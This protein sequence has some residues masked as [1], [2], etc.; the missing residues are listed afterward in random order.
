[1]KAADDDICVDANRASAYVAGNLTMREAETVERHIDQCTECRQHLS[2][3]ARSAPDRGP[4]QARSL[5]PGTRVDRYVI[6]EKIGEG[7]MGVVYHARDPELGRS[8]ALKMLRAEL[9]ERAESTL[10]ATALRDRLVREARAMAQ[11]SH[12]NVVA[13]YDLVI[14]GTAL[15]I[16]M[17]FIE[18]KSLTA[19]LTSQ[20][21]SWSDVLGVYRQAG[22]G[23]AAAHAAG[24]VHRDFKPDNVLV[25][26]GRGRT[27]VTDFGLARVGGDTRRDQLLASLHGPAFSRVTRTGAR[28][29]TPAY[30]SPEQYRGETATARSDQFSFCIALYEAL[31]HTSPFEGDTVESRAAAV[32]AGRRRA[33][34]KDE[35][36]A[37]IDRVV[38]R[39]MRLAPG[40]RYES[41]AALLKALAPRSAKPLVRAAIALA[42]LAAGAGTTML[43]RRGHPTRTTT[44]AACPSADERLAGVWDASRKENVRR[45]F[46]ATNKPYALDAW[47]GTERSV[48]AYARDWSATYAATCSETS[49]DVMQLRR[50]ACLEERL[51][52]L[53]ALVDVFE[54]ADVALVNQGVAA[55][56]SLPRIARCSSGSAAL[57]VAA[58]DNPET[59]AKVAKVREQLAHIVALEE[60]QAWK[61]ALHLGEPALGEARATGYRPVVAQ[62]LLVIGDLN[63]KPIGKRERAMVAYREAATIADALGDDRTRAL[64]LVGLAIGDIDE[65]KPDRDEVI[66]HALAAAERVSGDDEVQFIVQFWAGTDKINGARYEEAEVRLRKAVVAAERAY[67]PNSWRAALAL[68]VVGAA[69]GERGRFDEGLALNERAL[70][71]FRQAVGAEAPSISWL[72]TISAMQLNELRRLPE[73]EAHLREGLRVAEREMGS[74][75]VVVADILDE[76]GRTLLDDGRFQEGLRVH[77][78]TLP[79]QEKRGAAEETM[80][81]LL[82]I[83]RAHLGMR[84]PLKAIPPLER[85]LRTEHRAY[86]AILR[87]QAEL[88][89]A[90]ALGQAKRSPARVRELLMHARDEYRKSGRSPRRERDVARIEALLAARR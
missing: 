13:V 5:D 3:L 28:M 48:D 76:L 33:R 47:R 14:D 80:A 85:V 40:D 8:I 79:I 60:T 30:M 57:H 72:H 23:L 70:Y 38:D 45:A 62:A 66:A 43:V 9:P 83:G 12:R 39:G 18:G 75:N 81:A 31:H 89:L 69:V 61:A 68:S 56:E 22:E 67:G 6:V 4:P 77:E 17:E 87:A 58:P 88:V 46:E 71:I 49:R 21:R 54:R 78:R 82:G 44:V 35:I 55:A 20:A 10:D 73:A 64:A 59:L 19:W 53:R 42:I 52:D 90:E 63:S 37:W 86:K 25:D 36:P 29:G 7:G 15:Y 41:M 32:M 16:A 74:D 84:A 2:E 26:E 1:M 65:K 51:I 24:L 11:L 50:M 34:P 27:C